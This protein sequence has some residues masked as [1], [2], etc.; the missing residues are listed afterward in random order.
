M[1]P[2][3]ETPFSVVPPSNSLVFALT[4][5][6]L[7]KLTRRPSRALDSPRALL[8]ELQRCKDTVRCAAIGAEAPGHLQ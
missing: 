3:R 4:I 1:T 8:P 2:H 7:F 6:G 5:E